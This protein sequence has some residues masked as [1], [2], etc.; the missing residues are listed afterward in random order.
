MMLDAESELS[1]I[2]ICLFV[3][4]LHKGNIL[5]FSVTYSCAVKRVL[6]KDL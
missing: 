6:Y 2:H 4:L 1:Y 3:R 5:C